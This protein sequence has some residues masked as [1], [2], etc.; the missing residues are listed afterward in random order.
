MRESR[1]GYTFYPE[2]KRQKLRE[3]KH[4]C[5]NPDCNCTS[6]KAVLEAHHLMP[7]EVARTK[8]PN[9]SPRMIRSIYN[10]IYLCHDCHTRV[11]RDIDGKTGKQLEIYMNA[12][13]QYLAE[14][15]KAMV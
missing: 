1:A 13:A 2:V 12:M 5:G 10:C 3:Q 7:I 6:K 14:E 11:H 9:L 15:F 4:K 8:Y